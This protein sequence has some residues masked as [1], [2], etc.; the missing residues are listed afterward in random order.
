MNG[1]GAGAWVIVGGAVVGAAV[2]YLF[3]TESGRR[4]RQR[5]EPA[6]MDL[7]D[8]V[9]HWRGAIEHVGAFAAEAGFGGAGAPTR[10][11]A[12][13]PAGQPV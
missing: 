10:G 6:L 7:M 5:L 2:G 4:M 12:R 3:F 1:R 11:E 8:N 13:E 9:Q